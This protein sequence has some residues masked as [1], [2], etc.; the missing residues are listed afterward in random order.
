[1]AVDIGP[2]IGIEGEAKFR[3]E[4]QQINQ[5]LKVLQSEAKAVSAAMQDET[6]AEKKSAAEKDVLNRQVQTQ[7]EKLAKLEE[8]LTKAGQK[9]GEAD[10]RTMKWQQAV[11]DASAAL[12]DMEHKLNGTDQQVEVLSND[13]GAAEKASAGWADVMKGNLLSDA[14]KS[15]F[16]ALVNLTKETAAAMWEASKAG[17]SY[18]DDILTLS[19]T[20]GLST[21]TLQE[22]KFMADLVDVSLDTITGSM[23]KLTASMIKAKAGE[24]DAAAVFAELGVSVTDTNGKLRRAQDVFNDAVDALGNVKNETERDAMAMKIFGKSAKDLNPLI[25]AGKV[26][27]QSLA[28]E[29]KDTGYVL[30]GPALK[31]LGAQQDAMERLD[32]KAEAL[33]NNFASKM[34][35]SMTRAYDTIAKTLDNPRVQRGLEVLAQGLGKLI[36]G[37]AELADKVLPKVLELFG[38]GDVRLRTFTDAELALAAAIDE[39]AAAYAEREQ[40]YKETAAAIIEETKRTEGLWKEL[41]TLADENGNVQESERDR[42][43]YILNELNEA[44]GT[45]YE[46]TGNQIARYKDMQKEIANLIKQRQAEAL[47]EAGSAKYTEDLKEKNEAL[48]KQGKA[49][50]ALKEAELELKIAED[51]LAMA[52]ENAADARRRGLTDLSIRQQ[53]TEQRKAVEDWKGKVAELRAEYEEISGTVQKA[54][55]YTAEYERAEAAFLAGDATTAVQILS[56]AAGALNEYYRKKKDL[57]EKDKEEMRKYIADG[58][59]MIRE[60]KKGLEAGLSGYT[61]A[62]LAELESYVAEA[63]RIL[64]GEDVAMQWLEGL[65]R[66]LGDKAKL[67]E[68][69]TAAK[70]AP[71][72]IVRTT[73]TTLSI[74]SP[75]RVAEWIGDMWDTGLAKGQIENLDKVVR[76]SERVNEAFVAPAAAILPTNMSYVGGTTMSPIGVYGSSTSSYTTNLGGIN[77]RIDGSDGVNEDVLAQRVAVRL[78]DELRRAQRGG[79]L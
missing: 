15:G 69:E 72:G 14:V 74:S 3:Q 30:S 2:K 77:I 17:A 61:D 20:T 73:R 4:L 22:Y 55:S 40:A 9:Y 32:K 78:S 50:D 70:L 23:T 65:K 43:N 7:R 11:Y 49:S 25:K 28:K 44:L 79:R 35:P 29:A 58:E 42:A 16:S 47:L 57:S 60:Y 53:T 64:N 33:K 41:Q 13:M 37:T 52:E 18:A 46:M 66:G 67:R 24:G 54:M 76:A 31:A 71:D 12:A 1:M 59:I 34:A 8:G 19:T 51:A 56:K 27:L 39:T 5:G 26:E 62:G 6:D 36:E 68:I 48:L 21:D 38:L 63:K 10:T 75:S 45:E